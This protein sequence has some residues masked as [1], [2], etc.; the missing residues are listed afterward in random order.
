MVAV[1]MSSLLNFYIY[2]SSIAWNYLILCYRTAYYSVSISEGLLYCGSLY[3]S[4]YGLLSMFV[5]SD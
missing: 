4:Y 3:K 1:S 2:R 5:G